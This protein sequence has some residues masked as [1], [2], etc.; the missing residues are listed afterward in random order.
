MGSPSAGFDMFSITS[1]TITYSLVKG[2]FTGV[3]NSSSDPLFVDGANK[4]YRLQQLSPAINAGNNAVI[5]PFN[6]NDT[7]KVV[8]ISAFWKNAAAA[9]VVLLLGSMAVNILQYNKN[10]TLCC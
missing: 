5:I 7:A 8:P 6:N 3:G 1:N 4:N 2:G 10:N 9:A